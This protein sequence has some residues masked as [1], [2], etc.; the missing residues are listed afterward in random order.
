MSIEVLINAG[1][2]EIRVA[3]VADGRLQEL[4]FERTIGGE[5]GARGC[6]SLVG[7]VI[8][9]RV[10]RVMAGMQAA[11]VDVG[12]E[13]AGFLALREARVLAK[14]PNDDTQISDCL[15]EGET[16]LVQVIK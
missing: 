16:L 13:R 1:A 8:L 11:F 15:R 12:L 14:E 2:G 9:G 5:D 6:H 4:S 10:S 3:L 7:D